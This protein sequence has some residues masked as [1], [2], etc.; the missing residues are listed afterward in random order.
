MK[1][2]VE[3]TQK[4]KNSLRLNVII[5]L[6]GLALIFSFSGYTAKAQNK[7]N[8]CGK[9]P[10]MVSQPQFSDED[11]TKWKGKSVSGRVAIV[12]SEEGD[13]TQARVV[14]ASPKGAAEALF[15]AAKQTKFKPRPGCGEIKSEVFFNLGH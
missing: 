5:I 6:L 15:G 9:P 11:K 7:K 4:T 10:K 13:V 14:D 8:N 12:V 3:D 1:F 2:K